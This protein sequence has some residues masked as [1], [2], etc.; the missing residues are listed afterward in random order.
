MRNDGTGMVGL[1]FQCLFDLEAG[2]ARKY[3]N[4]AAR[5]SA[6]RTPRDVTPRGAFQAA[7]DFIR[8]GIA[9]AEKKYPSLAS[10]V[11]LR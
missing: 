1:A 10:E 4:A 3:M 5:F 11:S 7:G 6:E 8:M 9:S 2:A